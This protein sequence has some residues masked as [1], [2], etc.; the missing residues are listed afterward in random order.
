VL[1][2]ARRAGKATGLVTTSQVTDATPA[3][4]GAHVKDRAEQSEIAKQYL[5]SSKPDVILGGG[6]DYWYPKGM[7]W[8]PRRSMCS[9]R[10]ATASWC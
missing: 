4:Y 3:A 7:R 1:E 9:P 10:T 5:E 8:R 6:E 2:D